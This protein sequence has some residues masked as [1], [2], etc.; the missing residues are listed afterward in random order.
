MCFSPDGLSASRV[1]NVTY[2]TLYQVM[3]VCN[4]PFRSV[5]REEV[6]LSLSLSPFLLLGHFCCEMCKETSTDSEFW[7]YVSSVV[8][9]PK[10]L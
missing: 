1:Q 9:F 7:L 8:A 6:S 4:S 2:V 3:H 10:G 5:P